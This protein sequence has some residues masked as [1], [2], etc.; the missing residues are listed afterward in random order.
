[1]V[2][3]SDNL[4]YHFLYLGMFQLADDDGQV[5]VRIA[6]LVSSFLGMAGAANYNL[7]QAF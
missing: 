5:V 3:H 6:E 2:Q 1:M 7:T 4:L